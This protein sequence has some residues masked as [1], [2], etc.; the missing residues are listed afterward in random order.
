MPEGDT[1]FRAATTLRK[2]LAGK[3]VTAFRSDAPAAVARASALVGR[4]VAS[5]EPYGKHLLMRFAL[6]GEP[7]LVLHT[8]LQMDGSWHIYRPGEPWRRGAS[9][10]RAVIETADFVAP[11]FDAPTVE[12]LTDRELARH[13]WMRA[14]GPD[15]MADD[16]DE[17]DALMRLRAFADAPI[18]V[19]IMDQRAFAGVGNVYKSEVLFGRR[20]SPFT[21]VRALSDE[22]LRGLIEEARTQLRANRTGAWPRTTRPGARRGEELWVY[23]RAGKACRVCGA[24]VTLTRQGDAGRATYYCPACQVDRPG[25]SAP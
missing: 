16:F 10:A 6:A 25:R 15:A 23:D 2:A 11:C 5:V 17:G 19:A 22:T 20:V 8:H 13:P 18:G 1:I 12:L 3:A 4:R 7:D 14:L 24:L 9:R 21:P